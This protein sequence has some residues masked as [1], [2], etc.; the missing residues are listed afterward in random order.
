MSLSSYTCS[1][2]HNQ[3]LVHLSLK[4]WY[5]VT[6]AAGING[7]GKSQNWYVAVYDERL[8]INSSVHLVVYSRGADSLEKLKALEL[9]TRLVHVIEYLCVKSTFRYSK[10]AFHGIARDQTFSLRVESCGCMQRRRLLSLLF[11]FLGAYTEYDNALKER[12]CEDICYGPERK[13]WVETLSN[14]GKGGGKLLVSHQRPLRT[15]RFPWRRKGHH[16]SILP[17]CVERRR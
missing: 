12:M 1:I 7:D 17:G 15:T 2:S 13:P 10:R 6:L 11:N 4:P 3:G 16:L 9:S 5:Q 8:T 14:W